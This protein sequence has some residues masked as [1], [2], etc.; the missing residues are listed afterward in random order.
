[1]DTPHE[2]PFGPILA[3]G[4]L[5]LLTLIA[6][7]VPA[8]WFGIRPLK[9][10]YGKID[11]SD[12]SLSEIT[13][14]ADKDGSISWK[15]VI[16]ENLSPSEIAEAES[17]KPDPVAI[18]ALNDPNN[19]TSS[20]SKNLYTVSTY[21]SKNQLNDPAAEQEVLN[22]LIAEE[23]AKIIP[24]MYTNKDVRVAKTEDKISVRAYG[25]SVASILE[26]MITEARIVEDFSSVASFV[27]TKDESD[28]VPLVKD[29]ERVDAK[30]KKLL[31]LSVPLSAASFHV[32]ALNRVATYRDLLYNLSKA[33]SDPIRATLFIQKYPET[34]ISTLLVFKDVSPYFNLK[35]IVF[36]SKE[37]GYPFTVGYTLK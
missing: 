22:Q 14:D 23:A 7:I 29:Y 17:K 28:L 12:I 25:N 20:F 19:L 10:T 27:D 32:I 18:A 2:K 5:V 1:M 9:H 6:S 24:T 30:L 11:L 36:T 21:L 16:T 4:A 31:A 34:V 15:E 35:N 8:S 13:E 33:E 26:D 3:I 37:P